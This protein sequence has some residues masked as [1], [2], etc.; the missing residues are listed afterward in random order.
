MTTLNIVT[1]KDK[2]WT[3]ASIR[4]AYRWC[5][6]ARRAA[7]RQCSEPSQLMDI[8]IRSSSI[9]FYDLQPSFLETSQPSPP[10]YLKGKVFESLDKSFVEWALEFKN[11]KTV[12]QMEYLLS[13]FGYPPPAP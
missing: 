9:V 7:R 5:G 4:D 11:V 13:F 10:C 8:N 1:F 3:F 12:V 6:F 2:T